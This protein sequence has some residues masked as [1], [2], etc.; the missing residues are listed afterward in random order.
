MKNG[1]FRLVI[2]FSLATVVS[3]KINAETSVGKTL[4]SSKNTIASVLG[5]TKFVYN[6]GIICDRYDIS[7]FVGFSNGKFEKM[8]NS[9]EAFCGVKITEGIVNEDLNLFCGCISKFGIKTDLIEDNTA[10][11]DVN[12]KNNYVEKKFFNGRNFFILVWNVLN[13]W[14]T[15]KFLNTIFNHIHNID[16][17]PNLGD[18]DINLEGVI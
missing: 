3:N 13:V 16:I 6:S 15:Y 1:L 17:L 12:N 11:N 2:A 18:L 14:N 9:S 5:N 7:T 8:T 10:N 4:Q